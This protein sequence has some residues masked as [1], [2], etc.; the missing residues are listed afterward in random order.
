MLSGGYAPGLPCWPIKKVKLQGKVDGYET[1]DLII[2]VENQATKEERKLFGQ[3]KYSVAI[4][5]KDSTFKEVISAAWRDY[6]NAELFT[7]GKDVIALIT[8]PMSKTDVANAQWIL[9]QARH[10]PTSEEFI[11]RIET[12]KFG[13]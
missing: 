10:V 2:F 8:G 1:D 12:A 7:K 6:N 11:R 9:N 5:E 3:V 4:T 13:P